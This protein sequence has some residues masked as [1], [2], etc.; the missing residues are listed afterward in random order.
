MMSVCVPV[1]MYQNTFL[2]GAIRSGAVEESKA[3]WQAWLR[4]S[5]TCVAYQRRR[6]GC[7]AADNGQGVRP[8]PG[9][10]DL[11]RAETEGAKRDA[12]SNV[13][14]VALE[15]EGVGPIGVKVKVRGVSIPPRVRGGPKPEYNEQQALGRSSDTAHDLGDVLM[16]LAATLWG[17]VVDFFSLPNGSLF[18]FFCVTVC[19]IVVAMQQQQ[20]RRL[21]ERVDGLVAAIEV[22]AHQHG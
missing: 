9:I 18:L 13:E 12:A 11:A 2:R 5:Q 20:I 19:L 16:G 6:L 15:E 7:T 1:H 14:H 22:V 17:F 8:P 3:S 10:F 21:E 4:A